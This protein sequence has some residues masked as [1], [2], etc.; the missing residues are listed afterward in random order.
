MTIGIAI[1][2]SDSVLLVADGRHSAGD[3]A[4]SDSAEKIKV[5]RD[6]LAVITFGVTSG[7]DIALQ[8]LQEG[9]P[10]LADD[11][12]ACVRHCVY[13]GASAV[14]NTLPPEQ[15]TISRMK[16]GLV[17][18]GIDAKGPYITGSLFGS[19][20]DSPDT[21]TARY[22]IPPCAHLILGGE[23]VGA[24]AHFE[25]LANHAFP[26]R[27]RD[28]TDVISTLRQLAI[29]T[30]KFAANADPTIGGRIQF[31]L[32]KQGQLPQTGFVD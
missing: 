16:V 20:M 31:T 1:A 6:D 17:G 3:E 13:A 32:L 9:I 2:T 23:R 29:Q 10:A 28:T 21:E 11:V 26:T 5:L 19:N 27:A 25:R 12:A 15:R 8:W 14:L 30:V 24:S 18:G 4:V 22:N 7:T